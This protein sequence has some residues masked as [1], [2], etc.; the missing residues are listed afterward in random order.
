MQPYLRKGKNGQQFWGLYDPLD[1]V[2]TPTVN[3]FLQTQIAKLK[4]LE[5]GKKYTAVNKFLQQTQQLFENH[6]ATAEE[7][8]GD[9]VYSRIIEILNAGLRGSSINPYKGLKGSEIE[10]QQQVSQKI[11]ELLSD[12]TLLL[13]QA[14]VNTTLSTNIVSMLEKRLRT[15]NWKTTSHSYI[16]E[17][18]DLVEALMAD[19]MNQNP[20]LRAIVTGSWIDLSGKQLI[21]DTFAF[22]KES[23]SIPFEMGKLNFTIKTDAGDFSGEAYSIKDFL[24][25]LDAL[26]S[27]SFKV[28]LSDELYEALKTGSIIAGQAKSGQHG[29]AILN[30]NQR[31]SL[32]LSEVGFNPMLLWDLYQIDKETK[33]QFFKPENAQYSATLSAL[34][35]YCLS[36][37]IALTALKENQLY[38]TA[39]GFVTASQW[40]ERTGSYLIFEPDITT[41]SGDFLTKKRKYVFT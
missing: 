36:K 1:K 32:S 26:N 12:L 2:E 3:L 25:Q 17:K 8:I 35:N 5:Q 31:N 19:K 10:R 28:Q 7:K 34:C 29:Q 40:M 11:K 23:I 6:E 30:K 13:Q 20:A 9:E 41:I 27:T 15:F 24:D 39:E 22:S 33:T 14:N 38:L 21:E 18:A 37:N 4:A 16:M